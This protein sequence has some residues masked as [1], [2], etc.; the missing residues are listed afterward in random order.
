LRIDID[1]SHLH[2]AERI[3]EHSIAGITLIAE[4]FVFR[5][6]V[7]VQGGLK[8]VLTA[9]GETERLESH[10]L[11]GTIAGEYHQIGPGDFV[12]IFLL[13]GPKQSSGL[14]DT[15]I[16]GPAIERCEANSAGART[17]AAII[18]AISAGA[19]PCHADE[20]RAVMA[21]VRRPPVLRRR[22]YFFDVLLQGI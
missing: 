6:P 19:M 11:Q 3:V 2:G 17:A 22:H 18:D 8:D 5:S 20:E 16:V 12:A 13:D 9:A 10:R 21:I 4:P 1:K 15:D 7:N 14:V